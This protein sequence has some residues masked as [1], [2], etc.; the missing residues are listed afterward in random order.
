[1]PIQP[2]LKQEVK[3]L[4]DTFIASE[5]YASN[6]YKHIA[7]QMQRAGCFGAQKFFEKESADELKHYE[8]LRNYLND[9]GCI[10]AMPQIDAINDMTGGIGSALE[11]GYSTEVTLLNKYRDGYEQVEDEMEDCITA[12]FLL[13]FL[14]I[15]VK[16]VG[17]YSD[18][19]SRF[20]RNPGD[21]FE[22]DEYM[23]EL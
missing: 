9:M 16:S 22:F 2:L 12:N 21:T 20:E 10:A 4:I 23:G 13:Q 6:L 18:L 11:L 17:E 1:M 5:L 19:I 3:S 14:T 15:Q 7:A 8:I